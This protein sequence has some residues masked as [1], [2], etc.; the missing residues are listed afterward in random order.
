[1]RLEEAGVGAGRVPCGFSDARTKILLGLQRL[2]WL[3][4][5]EAEAQEHSG[6]SGEGLGAV[7]SYSR[8]SR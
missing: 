2:V 8:A 3:M 4:V 5:F 7:S 1:M 6:T